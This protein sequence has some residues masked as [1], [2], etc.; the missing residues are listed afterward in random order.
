MNDEVA[1]TKQALTEA[2]NLAEEIL[3]NIELTQL[4]LSSIALKACR[5]ARL[6]NDFAYLSIFDYEVSGYPSE[7][8]GVAREVWQL[9]S[10]AGRTYIH[11]SKEET[12]T[13]AYLSP[14]AEI[15][16]E[17]ETAKLGIEA[18]KD[19]SIS[20]SS[21]NPHQYLSQPHG[22]TIERRR[23][24]EQ[25]ELA[26]KR[27]AARRGLIHRYANTKYYELKFSGIADD[28]FARLRERVDAAI[29]IVVPDEIRRLSA[30][31]DNLASD[32]MEDWSNAVH[33][34]RR[35][36]QALADK[37][38]PPG[39]DVVKDI[40]GKSTKIKMG[41]ENYINRLLAYVQS[42]S[43][44]DRFEAIVGSNLSFIGE[45]LD[46]AFKAAQKGSHA[47]IVD[48]LEADRYVVNTYIIVGDILTL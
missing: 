29:G 12:K 27:L 44:S 10:A 5:L 39:D 21:A 7:E 18:A 47:K 19:A 25:A 26:A 35:L 16:A 9:A 42:K 45:R 43:D 17:L 23:L 4:D 14:I 40:G 15:E 13:V 2:F 33:S 30:I 6:L 11:K 24:R 22:N 34:C 37:L 8:K 41:T 38:Y 32:N 1:P 20:I 36:L 46:A 28:I 31:Y 48:R 3:R